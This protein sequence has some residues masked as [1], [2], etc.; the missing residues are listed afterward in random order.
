MF[1]QAKGQFR[2]PSPQVF[3]PCEHNIYSC[4][5]RPGQNGV[6]GG[7]AP[8]EIDDVGPILRHLCCGV[9]ETK[10]HSLSQPSLG[11]GSPHARGRDDR[12]Q[13]RLLAAQDPLEAIYSNLAWR[14]FAVT[15]PRT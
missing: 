8:Q 3:E 13:L 5:A 15:A 9:Y 11:L 4:H 14:I 6:A 2:F 10:L 7:H 12:S 1:C